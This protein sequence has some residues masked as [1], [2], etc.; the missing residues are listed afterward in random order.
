MRSSLPAAWRIQGVDS[1]QEPEPETEAPGTFSGGGRKEAKASSP[2]YLQR[3]PPRS[4]GN[5]NKP[6]DGSGP[7]E[8]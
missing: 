2:R 4:L 8:C 5:G 6:R 3:A 7:R 1:H